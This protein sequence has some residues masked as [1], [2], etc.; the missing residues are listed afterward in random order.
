MRTGGAVVIRAILVRVGLIGFGLFLAL[1]SIEIYLRLS[2]W[3]LDVSPDPLSSTSRFFRSND[4]HTGWYLKPNVEGIYRKSCFESLVKINSQGFRDVEHSLAKPEGVY[5][6][7][8]L[9]DS[10]TAALQV[11]VEETFSKVLER[12][13]NEAELGKRFEVLNLGMYSFG[14]DQEYLSLKY[15]GLAY[16]PDMVVLAFFP[17]DVKNSS[18][19]LSHKP[20]VTPKPYFSLAHNGELIPLPPPPYIPPMSPEQVQ[21]QRSFPNRLLF[22]LFGWLRLYDW[23]RDRIRRSPP[24]HNLFWKLNLVDLSEPPPSMVYLRQY[25]PDYE[26]A[27][28][29]VKMLIREI[30]R[31][32]EDHGAQFLLLNLTQAEQLA[33]PLRMPWKYLDRVIRQFDFDKPSKILS[34]LSQE[35]K[36]EYLDLVPVFRKYIERERLDVNDIHLDC[37][38]HWTTLGHRLAGGTL[39]GKVVKMIK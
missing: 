30:R 35:E 7:V 17:N 19:M 36:I 27:W 10:M 25:P 11:N 14:T 15:Y 31:E 33:S 5:R 16:Q 8:V 6:V 38:G 37:D 4:P 1:G 3:G 12:F 9:G 13:L 39:V 23:V 32:S 22:T 28:Q 34:E 26:E 24:L 21:S 18:F 2:Q 29:I 20:G